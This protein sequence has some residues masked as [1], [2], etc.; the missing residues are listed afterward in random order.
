MSLIRRSLL[1]ALVCASLGVPVHASEINGQSGGYLFRG[2]VKGLV[3]VTQDGANV[4]LAFNLFGL[5]PTTK[6]RLVASRKGCGASGGKV[7]ARSFTTDGRGTSWD[8]VPIRA[9][10][11]LITS[12]SVRDRATGQVV[13]CAKRAAVPLG[14][15]NPSIKID[16]PKAVVMIS[17]ADALWQLIESFSGLEPSTQYRT[18]ALPG[19]CV[20]R[21]QPLFGKTFRSNAQGDALVRVGRQQVAGKSI[22]AVA[23]IEAGSREVLFCRTL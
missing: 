14:P 20:P 6:Y 15:D 11:S 23:L 12:M 9:D 8:P 4:A 18:V 1:V 13:A 3:T 5:Q 2:P 21:S 17:E 16:A 7:L 19:G 10:A 22:G